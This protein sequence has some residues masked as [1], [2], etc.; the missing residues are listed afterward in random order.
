MQLNTKKRTY[1]GA[2]SLL[3]FIVF[4]QSLHAQQELLLSTQTDNIHATLVNPANWPAGKKWYIGLPSLALDAVHSGKVSYGDVFKTNGNQRTIN[5]DDVITKLDARNDL[6]FIQRTE[7]FSIGVKLGKNL[8][9]LAHHAIR[10]QADI[11]YPKEALQLLWQGNAQFIGKT[12]VID[13]KINVFGFNE[14]GFG[15]SY[16]VAGLTIGARFKY[17]SGLGVVLSE[18]FSTSVYTDPDI[19]QLNLNSDI[20][21]ISMG[22]IT[23]IDTTANGFDVNLV[24]FDRNQLFTKNTGSSL[25]LGLSYRVNDRLTLSAS[26]IDVAGQI[27]WRNELK[28]YTS[29]GQYTY[30]GVFFD[31]NTFIGQDGQINVDTQLDSV[32]QIFQFTEGNASYEQKIPTRIYADASYQAT[33]KIQLGLAFSTVKSEQSGTRYGAGASVTWQPIK[34]VKLGT[35]VSTNEHATMQVGSLVDLRF[36]PARI[37]VAADNVLSAVLPRSQPSVAARY[38]F[39][40][41]F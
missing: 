12:V 38:G 37:Y 4:C 32:K 40:L 13:P 33:E 3:F 23:G 31:G 14:L 16:Q 34:W 18:R 9:L 24:K 36:G 8:R 21:V 2:I 22:L 1:R 30:N 27:R 15:G 5:L 7:T 25:D 20:S 29:R 39:G 41:V 11:T 35:M 28:R 17:L 26:A 19:Y 10:T 6:Q